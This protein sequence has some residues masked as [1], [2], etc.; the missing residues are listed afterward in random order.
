MGSPLSAKLPSERAVGNLLHADEDQAV[1]GSTVKG[2]GLSRTRSSDSV[3]PLDDTELQALGRALSGHTGLTLFNVD[4]VRNVVSGDWYVVDINYFPGIDKLDRFEER[5]LNWLL[6]LKAKS[7]QDGSEPT[8][9]PSQPSQPTQP[10]QPSQPFE[11]S[12][13]DPAELK[14]HLASLPSRI[15]VIESAKA[16]GLRPED[17]YRGRY[18]GPRASCRRGSHPRN[19]AACEGLTARPS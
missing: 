17:L 2:C 11:P 19:T 13:A 12:L 6:A 7:S 16:M 1:K 5:L 3:K 9:Q 18:G 15:A 14:A 4:L 10:S 8:A